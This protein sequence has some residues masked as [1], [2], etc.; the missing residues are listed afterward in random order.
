MHDYFLNLKHYIDLLP[1]HEQL[2]DEINKMIKYNSQERYSLPN[3][4]QRFT[5]LKGLKTIK[6]DILFTM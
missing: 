5:I 1:L 2:D 3:F 6:Q 4:R